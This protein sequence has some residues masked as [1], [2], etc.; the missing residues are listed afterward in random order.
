MCS[1]ARTAQASQTDRGYRAASKHSEG[2]RCRGWRQRRS[3]RASLERKIEGKERGGYDRSNREPS[4]SQSHLRYMLAFTRVGPQLKIVDERIENEKPDEGH[5][6]PWFYFN[7]N[8]GRPVLN[9]A[10]QRQR[11]LQ[12]EEVDPQQSILSQRQDPDQY[13]EVTYLGR[14][15]GSFRLYR[16]WSLVLNRKFVISTVQDSRT[17]FWKRI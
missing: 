6:R 15:F 7:Y 2:F 16:N 10:N 8:G 17:I 5:D 12:R 11:H 3:R 9:V 1:S 14:F 13:P 4:R